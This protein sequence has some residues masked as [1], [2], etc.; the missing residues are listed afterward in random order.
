MYYFRT[1][2][3]DITTESALLTAQSKITQP[4]SY[5]L[6]GIG[7][8]LRIFFFAVS[9]EMSAFCGTHTFIAVFAI[10]PSLIL[11]FKQMKVLHT[12]S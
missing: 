7:S 5:H 6:H 4:I 3:L 11:A 8:F 12:H 1:L 9:K 10:T 2:S